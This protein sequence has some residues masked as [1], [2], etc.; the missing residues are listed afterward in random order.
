MKEKIFSAYSEHLAG[1]RE[2]VVWS[3]VSSMAESYRQQDS[4]SSAV[5]DQDEGRV[6]R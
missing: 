6:F 5:E 1:R 4:S 3:P 2:R